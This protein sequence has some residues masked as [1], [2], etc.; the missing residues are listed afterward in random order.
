MLCIIAAS[1]SRFRQR[2]L[3]DGD[4]M[5]TGGHGLFHAGIVFDHMH[6]E[7]VKGANR[8]ELV[9]QSVHNNQILITILRSVPQCVTRTAGRHE[10]KRLVDGHGARVLFRNRNPNTMHA[11]T[12]RLRG[13]PIGHHT[14]HDVARI[15]TATVILTQNHLNARGTGPAV[16]I[17]QEDHA[18]HVVAFRGVDLAIAI[19]IAFGDNRPC[20]GAASLRIAHTGFSRRL[21]LAPSHGTTH[22]GVHGGTFGHAILAG[23]ARSPR[24][25]I[26]HIHPV[27]VFDGSRAQTHH[28]TTYG[29]DGDTGRQLSGFR[30]CSII[31]HVYFILASLTSCGLPTSIPTVFYPTGGLLGTQ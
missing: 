23:N 24:I 1:R 11:K 4:G 5:L 2:P 14:G 30:L 15:A 12:R 18:D 31:W 3:L 29:R 26:D 7:R 8:I 13:E 22:P 16:D 19:M 9:H 21:A 27:E 28:F 25:G 10:A 6:T 17:N 20:D